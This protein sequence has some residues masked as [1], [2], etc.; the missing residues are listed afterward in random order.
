MSVQISF[1]LN[2]QIPKMVSI[3][4]HKCTYMLLLLVYIEH[5]NFVIKYFRYNI[6]LFVTLL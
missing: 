4:L 2:S 1:L 3:L 5:Y 6:I